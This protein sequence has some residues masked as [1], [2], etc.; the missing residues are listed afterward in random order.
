MQTKELIERTVE[1]LEDEIVSAI[2][3]EAKLERFLRRK[4]V[5]PEQVTV[6]NNQ[7]AIV[8]RR[9]GRAE[10]EL[11]A[12]LGSKEP[13]ELIRRRDRNYPPI[14]KPASVKFYGLEVI[15]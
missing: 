9:I 13:L 12:L 7:I 4:P 6:A 3:I 2:Y 1:D 5:S 8:R 15:R 10:A 14:E 11:K